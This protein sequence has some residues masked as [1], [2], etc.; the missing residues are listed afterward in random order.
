MTDT[1]NSLTQK[2]GDDM[3]CENVELDERLQTLDEEQWETV[4]P[5]F[6]WTVKDQILHLHQVDLFSMASVEERF[7]PVLKQ[8]R[9]RQADGIELSEQARIDF[10]GLSI[11]EIFDRWRSTYRTLAER[12]AAC[13]RKVRLQWFG[14]PMSPL[15]MLSAR[16]MEVWAHSQ[17]IYDT[18]GWRREPKA[19][20]RNV[21]ELGI[22]TFGWSFVNRK[23][24]V[25]QRPAVELTAPSGEVWKW[26][27]EGEGLVSGSALDFAL[28][29]T[30]RRAPEDTSLVATGEA[31][32]AWLPVAQCFAG[33]PQEPAG[34][35][36]RPAL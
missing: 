34:P 8:V 16:Q 10:A 17:D 35:G 36:S 32:Q 28:V 14:P 18:F 12:L 27:G 11:A 15:S 9:Q 4:T 19:R 5:F 3:L 26:E 33:A 24:P 23:L 21:C 2:L 29:V 6:N 22:K 30:Q 13:D 31:A 20:I 1:A 7:E 25:P